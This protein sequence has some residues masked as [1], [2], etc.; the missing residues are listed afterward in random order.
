[1]SGDA[2]QEAHR[3]TLGRQ[4]HRSVDDALVCMCGHSARA[5][6]HLRR[7]DDCGICGAALCA[8]YR[9]AQ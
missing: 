2:D 3:R 4:R 7:G 8:R 1:M 9:E 6:E 5:H